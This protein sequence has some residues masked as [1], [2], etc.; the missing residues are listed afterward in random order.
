MKLIRFLL[1]HIYSNWQKYILLCIAVA[2]FLIPNLFWGGLY[3]VG[4]D[5][6]RFYYIFPLEYLKNFSFNIISNN[7]LGGNM[8][9]LPVSYAAPTVLFLL[10]L[11]TVFP[12]WNTQFI[13]YGLL[14]SFGFLFYYLFLKEVIQSKSVFLFWSRIIVS[15]GYIFSTYITKTFFQHQLISI[16]SIL[17][18]PACL[19]LFIVGL[20]KQK[21]AFIIASSIFYSLFSST[22]LG[23]PWFLPS[24]LTL[25]PFFIYFQRSNKVFFWRAFITFIL[26]SLICNSF[27]LIHYLIPMISKTGSDVFV[28]HLLSDDYRN[29]ND[30]AIAAITNLN[31]P[32]NQLV[33]HLRTSWSDREGVTLFQSI[34]I[35]Y[36]LVVLYAGSLLSHVKK[37][38]RYL[39]VIVVS[40]LCLAMFFVTPNYGE[41]NLKI[42]QFF[43]GHIPLFVMFR[44][45]Y[46]KFALAMAFQ[47]AFSVYVATYIYQEAKVRNFYKYSI[48]FC[49]ALV[50][51]LKAFPY[52]NIKYNDSDYSSR[53]S[54]KFNSE[55]I[56]LTDYLRKN[57]VSSR[58]L[59]ISMTY[60]GYIV[61]GDEKEKNHFYSGLSM[62]QILS[63][64]SDISGYY[65]IQTPSNPELN[66]TVLNLLRRHDYDALGKIFQ[67]QNIG[68]II[69]N[70]E[71][72]PK[73]SL[74]F[75][76]ENGIISSQSAEYRQAIIGKKVRDFGNKYSLYEISE[77][78]YSPTVFLTRTV[79]KTIGDIQSVVFHKNSNGSFYVKIDTISTDSNLIL[80]EPYNGLWGIYL[81]NEK[82]KRRLNLRNTVAYDFGNAWKLEPENLRVAYPEF[83]KKTSNGNYSMQMQIEFLPSKFT[84]PTVVISVIAIVAG[85][86]YIATHI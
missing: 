80:L 61:I 27:W 60:P 13:A 5:D 14:L 26:Y 6:G 32:V 19:Y 57:P 51:L 16:Y 40:G 44:N 79:E 30:L 71:I 49:L 85:L 7:T 76:D 35:I 70:H 43:N 55:F 37:I 20:K 2:I 58:Y 77:K 81:I 48:I 74:R 36:L 66:V 17:V 28:N 11:K 73:N 45:M 39:F 33:N 75:L 42:F 8:G 3:N 25:I 46:D 78:Y 4:G 15:I 68:Y 64:S 69:E 34:G 72:L 83:V 23:L 82:S 67:N 59:W 12:F 63:K 31:S 62:L 24:I 52:V 21:L 18:V 1:T 54:G 84:I 10:F 50:T 86:F 47:V 56:A 22:L 29:Q 53:I 9:Y 38:D 65:G 41:M